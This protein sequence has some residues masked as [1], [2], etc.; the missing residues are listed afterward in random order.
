MVSQALHSGQCA[1]CPKCNAC[2]TTCYTE[3]IK[4]SVHTAP[5]AMP[6][7]PPVILSAFRAVCTLPRMQCL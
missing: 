5:N 7:T 6:A 3:C 2:D 4:G 1:Q